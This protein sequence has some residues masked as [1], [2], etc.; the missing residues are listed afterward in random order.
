MYD[1]ELFLQTVCD[2]TKR[3][4]CTRERISYGYKKKKDRLYIKF[5]DST[6]IQSE[7]DN[8]RKKKKSVRALYYYVRAAYGKRMRIKC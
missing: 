4:Q 7:N 8:N 1:K 2:G 6:K 3:V 5:D